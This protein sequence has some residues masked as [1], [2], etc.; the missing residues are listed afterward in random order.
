MSWIKKKEKI[1]EINIFKECSKAFEKETSM[2]TDDKKYQE[3][4]ELYSEIRK[5]YL[6]KYKKDEYYLKVEK[7]RLEQQLGKYTSDIVNHNINL[8]I[9]IFS[10]LVALLM[11]S[12]GIF[13]V[14]KISAFSDDINS[15]LNNLLKVVTFLVILFSLIYS[16]T[17]DKTTKSQNEKVILGNIKLK[18]LEDIE[19]ENELKSKKAVAYNDV[20]ATVQND[21]NQPKELLKPN[22]NQANGNWNVEFHIP[23]V[24]E[25]VIGIYGVSNLFKKIFGKKK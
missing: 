23:S 12:I 19:K 18:V 22:S 13:D 4:R 14:I 5:Y 16:I 3:A 11:E 9:G 7:V 1:K 24:I 8:Y 20:A 21:E 2:D 6:A 10:A 15:S 25:T 17:S